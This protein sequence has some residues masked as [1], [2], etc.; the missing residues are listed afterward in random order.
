MRFEYGVICVKWAHNFASIENVEIEIN[1]DSVFYISVI[2]KPFQC[3]FRAERK[4]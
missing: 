2:D 3:V 4:Q 1:I